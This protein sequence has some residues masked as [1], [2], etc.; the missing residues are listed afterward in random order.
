MGSCIFTSCLME[1]RS[2][3][4]LCIF[5]SLLENQLEACQTP[6]ELCTVE[7]PPPRLLTY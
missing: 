5:C 4:H 7:K 1:L 2:S 3:A 6:V